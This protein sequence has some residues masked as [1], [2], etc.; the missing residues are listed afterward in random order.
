MKVRLTKEGK[1]KLLLS[2]LLFVYSIIV[3]IIKIESYAFLPMLWSMMGDIC[4]MSSRGCIYGG[5]KTHTFKAGIIS[6]A[7]AHMTYIAIMQTKISLTF[8]FI[9]ALLFILIVITAMKCNK[10]VPSAIYAIILILNFVNSIFFNVIATVGLASFI[11]SDATLAKYEEKEEKWQI[12]IWV[13]YVFAQ[14][15]IL[16][17]LLITR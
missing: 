17:S 15:C 9:S 10:A 5:E 16:T 3:S 7:F 13:T 14:I 1:I 4:I 12:L 2:S 11:I 6:F 8:F